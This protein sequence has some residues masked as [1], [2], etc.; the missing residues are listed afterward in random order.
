[1]IWIEFPKVVGDIH[2]I[3][4]QNVDKGVDRPW[5]GLQQGK[6][7]KGRPEPGEPSGSEGQDMKILKPL[8]RDN[9]SNSGT[10]RN[11]WHLP[12]WSGSICS[13]S[14]NLMYN[15]PPQNVVAWKSH[16]LW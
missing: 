12:Q 14:G 11:G 16:C 4:M 10:Q 8:E 9:I 15:K 6:N 7:F 13:C 3:E 1:M 2:M 5:P